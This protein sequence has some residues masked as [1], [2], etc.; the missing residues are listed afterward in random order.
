MEF[1]TADVKTFT[2]TTD[3][4]KPLTYLPGQFFMLVVF[5][6]GE[7]PF[8][9][10]S[11]AGKEFQ[12]TIRKAGTVTEA[13]HNLNIGDKI[14]IRGPFGNPFP[15]EELKKASA[16]VIVGGGIGLPP[17]RSLIQHI[18]ADEFPKLII[19]YGARTPGDLIYKRKFNTWKK[20]PKT[21]MHITVD[22]GDQTWK[23]N[24]GV[25][26]TLF[27]KITVPEKAKVVT[28]GPEIMMRFVI[29]KCLEL[30]VQPENIIVSLENRMTCGV[31]KCGNCAYGKY[32]VCKDG[33]VFNYEQVKD[34]R[35]IL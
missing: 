10:S 7:A 35:G 32:L 15:L 25:V 9:F 33:P 34:I 21:E 17:L 26:T 20:S 1:E 4:N 30:G 6:V 22:K 11:I 13:L 18:H 2:F 29:L 31:G 19:L 14:G 23:G 5:G 24:V 12:S 27:D 28:V 8:A 16:I 3:D